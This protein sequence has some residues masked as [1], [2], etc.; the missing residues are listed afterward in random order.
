MAENLQGMMLRYEE[1]IS[2]LLEIISNDFCVHPLCVFVFVPFYLASM[3]L[4]TSYMSHG[5]WLKVI[6]HMDKVHKHYQADNKVN[7]NF[8]LCE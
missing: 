3:D 5:A 8:Y 7:T 4:F 6:G 2:V 1:L